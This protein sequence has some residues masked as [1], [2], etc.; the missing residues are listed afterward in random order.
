MLVS[1]D[2][3]NVIA[4][5]QP[6]V[7][8]CGSQW[9]QEVKK[10]HSV[11]LAKHRTAPWWWFLHELKHVRVNSI[12]F[13]LF[14]HLY[15]FIILCISWNNKK[16]FWYYWC[17]VQIWKPYPVYNPVPQG[18]CRHSLAQFTCLSTIYIEIFTRGEGSW[19]DIQK[20][21]YYVCRTRLASNYTR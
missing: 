2:T 17:T 19:H 13:I 3:V 21:Q 14:H 11:V 1:I 20:K 18:N 6:V 10:N 7:Q 15:D 4:A 9:R 8:A 12:I 5:C 16:C